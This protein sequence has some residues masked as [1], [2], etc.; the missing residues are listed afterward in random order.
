MEYL[1]VDEQQFHLHFVPAMGKGGG[2]GGEQQIQSDSG[3]PLPEFEAA[4]IASAHH[5][6]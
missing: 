4:E 1:E 3:V 5:C 2:K 6:S